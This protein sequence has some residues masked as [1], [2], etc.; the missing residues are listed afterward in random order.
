MR[1]P[2]L[3]PLVPVSMT[4]G[5]RATAHMAA[6]VLLDYPTP[7]RLAVYDTVAAAVAGLPAAVRERFERFLQRADHMDHNSEYPRGEALA[8]H[9]VATFD[10]KRRCC[11]YLSYFGAGDTRRRGMALVRF[12][13]AY[14]AAGWQLAADELPDYLPAVLEFSANGDRTI[15]AGLLGTHRQGIEVLRAALHA[16]QSPYADVVEAVCLTLGPLD[17]ETE[18][19]Y[20]ELISAGPPTEMVGLTSFSPLE[21][22]APAGALNREV[23]A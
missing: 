6:S 15:A 5:E 3:D 19:R 20:L 9:Y 12:A 11:L 7:E 4:D 17:A 2:V 13:E 23:R 18:R 8:A 1:L 14:R 21:P 10:M 16:V 22:F